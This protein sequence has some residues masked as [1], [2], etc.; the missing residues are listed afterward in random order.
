MLHLPGVQTG[1]EPKGLQNDIAENYMK[2]A[3][4]PVSYTHLDVYKRQVQK[5]RNYTSEQKTGV[6]E[7]KNLHI[8]K[9]KM[10]CL[11]V[12]KLHFQK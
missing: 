11:E 9:C 4:H 2:Q 1:A 5:C 6:S 10:P 7:V 8:L 12:K 3:T